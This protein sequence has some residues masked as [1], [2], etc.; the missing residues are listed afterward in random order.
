VS[1]CFAEEKVFDDDE[2]S[3]RK[4]SHSLKDSNNNAASSSSWIDY[5][6]Y[7]ITLLLLHDDASSHHCECERETKNAGVKDIRLATSVFLNGSNETNRAYYS[8]PPPLFK[9][10]FEI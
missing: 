4:C 10:K 3:I 1:D 2:Y 8:P 7:L 6:Y 5:Y 9:I